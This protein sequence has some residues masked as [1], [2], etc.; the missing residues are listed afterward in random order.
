M[1]AR[2]GHIVPC[3]WHI[4]VP[5]NEEVGV[6][7]VADGITLEAVTNALVGNAQFG[8]VAFLKA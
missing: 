1:L 6:A 7:I 2:L 4:I 5:K 3:V 8:A